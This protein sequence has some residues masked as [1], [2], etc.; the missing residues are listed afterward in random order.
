M[1]RTR[2]KNGDISSSVLTSMQPQK[3]CRRRMV[4]YR[5]PFSCIPLLR[6]L[7]ASM[8]HSN[9]PSQKNTKSARELDA[10]CFIYNIQSSMEK[11]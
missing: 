7:M 6:K 9:L 5:L 10:Q 1:R 4:V 2:L 3:N 8:S 11:I